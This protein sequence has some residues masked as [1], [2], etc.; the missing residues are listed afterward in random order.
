MRR[1]VSN[2]LRDIGYMA[3]TEAEDGEDAMT[4]LAE[5]TYDLVITDWN[6]PNMDGLQLTHAIR[7]HERIGSLPVLM[8]TTRGL[9]QDVIAAM[10][11]GVNGYV[12]KPFAPDVLKDKISLILNFREPVAS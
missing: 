10:Q 2:S 12:V 9:K 4:K 11:A 1:I 3:V 5:D 8:V 6:M 7:S